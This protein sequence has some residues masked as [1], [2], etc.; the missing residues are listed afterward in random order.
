M[1]WHFTSDILS[2]CHL[3]LFS[4]TAL[5]IRLVFHSVKHQSWQLVIAVKWSTNSFS[6][7]VLANIG[8]GAVPERL[9]NHGFREGSG[10]GSGAM[11]R[12]GVPGRFWGK[13]LGAGSGQGSNKV[14]GQVPIREVP[15]QVLGRVPRFRGSVP[16][17]C[18][19][20]FQA[21]RSGWVHRGPGRV[22][23]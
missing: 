9:P 8:F 15:G 6:Y 14:L 17:Q 13:V 18:S 10:A 12:D 3:C 11:F 16:R 23:N 21:G 20:R 1:P 22:L 19:G 4:P 7:G 5:A 2:I